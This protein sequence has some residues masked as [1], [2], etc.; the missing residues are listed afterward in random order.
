MC[1]KYARF[2]EDNRTYSRR[3]VGQLIDFITWLKTEPEFLESNDV[4][5][6]DV[7][8]GPIPSAKSYN[9]Y[10]T[11]G[12][13]FVTK[14]YQMAKKNQNSG[15]STKC[16]TTLRSSAKDKNPIDDYMDYYGVLRKIIELEYR[17]GYRTV[18]FKC[19]WVK[20]SQN[21]VKMDEVANLRMVNLCNLTSSEHINDEPFIFGDE[22]SQV[23]Y[24]QDPK[25]PDW[26]VVVE[27]PKKIYF[28]QDEICLSTDPATMGSLDV[29]QE[30]VQ[31]GLE[32]ELIFNDTN[33]T[34][35][36]MEDRGKKEN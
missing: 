6:K 18:L 29:M 11:N 13:L 9:K 15:V 33:D 2:L 7:V 20:C 23:F 28:D 27:V 30:S 21:G 26:H 32:D 36:V 19:D 22:A 12:F 24:S 1:R 3:R 35:V 17:E 16:L 10:C 4:D 31:V 14:D 5:F 34:F 8:R 25:N